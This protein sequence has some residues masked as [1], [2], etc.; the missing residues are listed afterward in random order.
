MVVEQLAA[1][2]KRIRLAGAGLKFTYEQTVVVLILALFALAGGLMTAEAARPVP[3]TKVEKKL[4][5]PT[6]PAKNK[7]PARRI[8]IHVAGE[9]ARPGLHRLPSGSRV[10]D[11]IEAA[12]GPL[13][14]DHLDNLNL[15]A[16]L[17]DGQKIV[18][19][20]AEMGLTGPSGLAGADQSLGVATAVNINTAGLPE[21]QSL[22]GVGPVLA[23]RIVSWR[24]KHGRFQRIGQLQQVA[25][26]GPKK[27]AGI[28]D[29]VIT[30]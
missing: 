10:A 13:L 21:L 5:L 19:G 1:L 12:G 6:A 7:A 20:P 25:G 15:A 18:V 2:Q 24:K 23:A 26:I 4:V 11:A 22:D 9:V 29:Q 8:L 30:E 28:Q 16:K 17:G 27:F 3:V 14:G